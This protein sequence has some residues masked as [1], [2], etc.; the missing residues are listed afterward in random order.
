MKKNTL[1][2]ILALLFASVTSWAQEDVIEIGTVDELKAFR[3]AVNSGNQYTGKTVKL[4]SDLDLSSEA[5]W[6]PIGNLVAYPGQSFNGTFD[7]QDHTISNLTVVDNT[8]NYAVAGLFGSI[9]N[10]TIKNLTVSNVNIQ[11]THYAGGIV[12]Y[13]SNKPT[14]ENCHVKGGTISS[15]P[16][17]VGS[18]FDNGDK[19]GGIMGYATAY[20]TIIN[21]SVE[22]VTLTAYRDLGGVAGYSA[23]TVEDCQVKNVNLVQNLTNGY[24]TPTPTTIAEIVGRTETTTTLTDNTNTEV[25]KSTVTAVAKIGTVEYATLQAA[26]DA[27]TSG[28]TIDILKDFTL[29]T[30]TTDPS[31]KY[32]VNVNKSLTINGNNHTLT[33][34]TGKRALLLTGTDNTITLK[35]LT[36]KNNKADWTVGISNKLTANLDNVTLDGTGRKGGYNQVLT[37]TGDEDG[38]VVNITHG[39]V[40]K[41]NEAGKAHYAIIVW[42]KA[43]INVENSSLIGWANVYLKPAAAGSVVN[44]KN[45]NMTS[46]GLTGTSNNFAMI[47]SEGD[48]ND[49]T[50]EN[51]TIENHAQDGT[52]ESLLL[53]SGKNNTVKIIGGNYS[54]DNDTYGG[55]THNW[56][57]FTEEMGNGVYFDV[58]AK[59]K[60]SSYV[61]GTKG[62]TISD[63]TETVGGQQLYPLGYEPDVFYYWD[64]TSGQ[65]G[66]YCSLADP[67]TNGW[68][69]NKEYIKLKKDV[70]MTGDITITLTDGQSFSLLFDGHTLTAGDYSIKM[71]A[72][73]SIIT[74]KKVTDGL[75]TAADPSTY[76]IFETANTDGTYTYTAKEGIVKNVTQNIVYA[77]LQQAVNGVQTGETIQ[78]LDDI[79]QADHTTISKGG[80]TIDGQGKTLSCNYVDNDGIDPDNSVTDPETQYRNGEGALFFTGG[81]DEVT[82][83]GLSIKGFAYA[84]DVEGEGMTVTMNGG[85]TYGRAALN[86]HGNGNTFTFDGVTVNGL[87]KEEDSANEAFAA[88]VLD[89]DAN[90]NT[91]NITGCTVKT[92][93]DPDNGYNEEKFIELRGANNQVLIGGSTTYKCIPEDAGGFT[94]NFS[95]LANDKLFFDETAKATFAPMFDT[96]DLQISDIESADNEGFY[97]LTTTT[98]LVILD[99]LYRYP[100]FEKAYESEYFNADG[101][102]IK[103]LGPVTLAKDFTPA[104]ANGEMIVINLNGKTLK[105]G[106]YHINL[107]P[108]AIVEVIGGATDDTKNLFAATDPTTNIVATDAEDA[109]EI[110]GV[111]YTAANC[112]F[113]DVA[114]MFYESVVNE[115]DDPEDEDEEPDG[116]LVDGS[117][118]D[119]AADIA[120]TDN[121]DLSIF[122]KENESFTLNFGDYNF[123]GGKNMLLPNGAS[124]TTDKQTDL[125]KPATD[126]SYI[127]ETANANGTTYT[128]SVTAEEPTGSAVVK[129]ENKNVYYSTLQAATAAANE[130][131]VLIILQ[132]ITTNKQVDITKPLTI[133]SKEGSTYKVSS[134][135][136]PNEYINMLPLF[137]LTGIAEGSVVNIQDVNIDGFAY[138][139][140]VE[141]SVKGVTLNMT[142]TNG[143]RNITGRAAINNW[144]SDNTFNVDGYNVYAM[145]NQKK[146]TDPNTVVEQDLEWF[147]AFVDNKSM[148][149][150]EDED[151]DENQIEAKNNTYNISNVQVFATVAEGD[152]ISDAATSM[153][154]DLRGSGAKVIVENTEYHAQVDANR[155]GFTNLAYLANAVDNNK[156]WFDENSKTNFAP[157]F[158]GVVYGDDYNDVAIQETKDDTGKYPL[159]RTNG[160]VNLVI[161]VIDDDQNPND[162]TYY[163]PTLEEAINSPHFTEGD[164]F[165]EVLSDQTLTNDVTPNLSKNDHFRL[166]LNGHE[167]TAAD[168]KAIYL[169][170]AVNV[171]IKDDETG[172]LDGLFKPVDEENTTILSE[173]DGQGGMQYA[174]ANSM[175]ED[176]AFVLFEDLFTNNDDAEYKLSAEEKVDLKM[177]INLSQNLTCPSFGGDEAFINFGKYTI[178][179][180][181]IAIVKG[182]TITTDKQTTIFVPANDGCYVLE[183]DNGNT[184]SYTVTDN[185]NDAVARIDNRYFSTLQ[186][187]T[188]VA[189]DGETVVLLKDIET[190]QPVNITT[191][192]TLNGDGYEVTSNN[193]DPAFTVSGNGDVTIN[194]LKT[195]V[196]KGDAIEVKKGFSGK[197]TLNNDTIKASRRGIDVQNIAD[198]F[199]LTVNN[200]LIEAIFKGKDTNT[201]AETDEILNLD[202]K[203]NYVNMSPAIHFGNDAVSA[204]VNVNYSTLQGFAYGVNVADMSG[205]LEVNLSN[206]TFYGRAVVNNW[207]EGNTFNIDN[208]SVNGL[209]NEPKIID[210][211]T[212]EESD[213]QNE[214]FATIVDN[215][216]VNDGEANYNNY[217][218]NNTKFT[219]NA[220]GAAS[221]YASEKFIDLRGN[222]ARVK[223]TG[224]TTYEY[225]GTNEELGGFTNELF[226]KNLVDGNKV[227]FDETAKANFT[228][229]VDA[230]CSENYGY[231]GILDETDDTN[232]YPLDRKVVTVVLNIIDETTHDVVEQYFYDSLDKALESEKF[233]ENVQIQAMDDVTL[234]K[235]HTI[236]VPF[237]LNLNYSKPIKND[238]GEIIEHVDAI[239]TIRGN[240]KLL[241][242]P[243]VAVDVKGG[244]EATTDG[245]FGVA[246]GHDDDVKIL[247]S[248]IINDTQ[249][250]DGRRYT[251]GN[252][253]YGHIYDYTYF[254][255]L[256]ND[257]PDAE[258]ALWP[259]GYVRLE[260]PFALNK[261]LICPIEGDEAQPDSVYIDFN[262]KTLDPNGHAI[263]LKPGVNVF[264][265]SDD[266]SLEKLFNS[267]D[268]EY[269]VMYDI[270]NPKQEGPEGFENKEFDRKYYLM[271][272]GLAVVVAPATYCGEQ[273]KPSFIVKRKNTETLKWDTLEVNVD[274]TWRMVPVSEQNN[275]TDAKTYVSSII[276]E[277]ITF[278][279]VRRADFTINPRNITDCQV[280]GNSI[281]FSDLPAGGINAQQI[282]DRIAMTYECAVVEHHLTAT[283]KNVYTLK[284]KVD[285]KLADYMVEVDFTGL[286]TVTRDNVEYIYNI[287]I[288]EDIITLT[289]L[290]GADGTQNFVGT[291]KVDFNILPTGAIDIAECVVT[292]KAIYN[293]LTQKPSYDLLEVVYNNGGSKVVL[294]KDQYDIEVHGMETD[295]VN[296]KTYSNAITLKGTLTGTP[297]FYGTVNAD[298]VIAPRDLADTTFIAAINDTVKV[299]LKKNLDMTWTG[300]D[301]TNTI[302]IGNNDDD[303]I[304]LYMQVGKV[305]AEATNYTLVNAN[306]KYDY[307]YT[308]EPSPMKDP[309]EYKVI[310]TGRGNF[311]GMNEVKIAVLK[312]F[313]VTTDIALQVI[314]K[315]NEIREVYEAGPG[316]NPEKDLQGVVVKDNQNGAILIDGTHYTI[317]VKGQSETAYTA[318][319]PIRNQGVYIATITGKYPYYTPTAITKEFPAVFEYYTYAAGNVSGADD[320]DKFGIHVTSGIDRTATVGAKDGGVA[321]NDD[322]LTLTIDPK[323]KVKLGAN[324]PYTYVELTI[325]GIDD[326]AFNG[327]NNLHYV[328]ASKLDGYEPSS[329]SRNA[330]GPFNGISKQAIVYLDGDDVIGENY[331][332]ETSAGDFRCD[333]FKIYDDFDGNQKGFDGEG[334]GSHSWEIINIHEFT[335]KTL[336]NTRYFN[337][338]QHY[339]TLLPYDLP[340]PETLKAY[341][342]TAASDGIF[343]FREI[344]EDALTSF[345]PYVLIPS[346]AGNLLS[347]TDAV[348][349]VTATANRGFYPLRD[350]LH[351]QKGE[352]AKSGYVLYGS[353]IY[354]GHTSRNPVIEGTYIM[355]SG[356]QWKKIAPNSTYDGAC[357]LPMRAYI[358]KLNDGIEG[359][360]REFMSAKFIDGVK[361]MTNDM[362]GDDWSNAEVYDL[363]GRKVDTTQQMRKGVYIVNGQKRIRK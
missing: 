253:Y 319:N 236:D 227:W 322:M 278:Q 62:Q 23:G 65:E 301:L 140:N 12:A 201:G 291:R 39:S 314:P 304:L 142:S 275:Y 343:G 50:L 251:A 158:D 362:V 222:S 105:G 331:V 1:Y 335:A 276:I 47:V 119:L 327:T 245:V 27:A 88:F 295:Y 305:E 277:G 109:G 202:P 8:P 99:D 208:M 329:L 187:A 128:Y 162:Y 70:T 82:I 18:G 354:M 61:D 153:F 250:I 160:G 220:D 320:A 285:D 225:V 215:N 332:Y 115:N 219:A 183:I 282:A 127:L 196:T 126:G 129:N 87:N 211:D 358:L 146:P 79:A 46:T 166:Q 357:I 168:G 239:A 97:P 68:L 303:N 135:A 78:I 286:E 6:K 233:G 361:E 207:G 257:D 155:Y 238:Q 203:E 279:G 54:T 173:T 317:T 325:N 265:N 152:D 91:L 40:I 288:Y 260:M 177:N 32:N 94:N 172:K 330:D 312:E 83:Q 138:A 24:K 298:Y 326:N 93:V 323:K 124:V 186:G 193:V 57:S 117:T 43:T 337:A 328:D 242:N 232:L 81:T 351:R 37:I 311:T 75:F 96:V 130:G 176:A 300:Q 352:I 254:N 14:I 89:D 63:A 171:D 197:L 204:K 213:S 147:A 111:D 58:A 342:L 66:T 256:F 191:A 113:D 230:F 134:G 237:E 315:V 116:W 110:V 244:S 150:D 184:F 324:P 10:G 53:L 229:L 22:N 143:S 192:I 310:F 180:G 67:F 107:A 243:G 212:H 16:E 2:I 248:D 217:N 95:D 302:K 360:S 209:N 269:T 281:K 316:L 157:L 283:G 136:N 308:I 266:A 170:P 321:V 224:N 161:T 241:L 340:L 71:P 353:M 221:S 188:N 205:K 348:V 44:I 297:K 249:T 280:T 214:F 165:I 338:G 264:T 175:Y 38:A 133:K 35:N 290:E 60:F 59:N 74:D 296:A 356:N 100:S 306:N 363:Q 346:A 122:I 345:M 218:I 42:K 48:G 148:P 206:G 36:V 139:V 149:E 349:K 287:G 9:V 289:A 5:N 151:E 292:S 92:T 293:S 199:E 102:T 11:S 73:V 178:E 336:T 313:N 195:Y 273:Q 339:T 294:T 341:N 200:S 25:T 137:N 259:D 72:G 26:V 141:N 118:I 52:Y 347:T 85:K 174:A 163:Y 4:T 263:L 112:I 194:K 108:G 333:E 255:D 274:Y 167:I 98:A 231:I 33:S 144:G 132:D 121:L 216:T 189:K 30:V 272:D 103:L 31:D 309:G 258:L 271:K 51:N 104:T 268:P 198:G 15:T 120:M 210:S 13:T 185:V 77:T 159:I 154:I 262:G 235:N 20:S 90:N 45:S 284:K 350:N 334:Q 69:A 307:S 261:D 179:G 80:F 246:A 145:N 270:L 86:V 34:A 318:T 267:A 7:G 240:G 359:H 41:T 226:V 19:V 190:N 28:S 223:I 64:T 84:I 106:G 164:A 234:D 125:F 131:D 49:I 355:Q 344:E 114:T 156:V 169:K 252:V 29:T 123:T 56:D 181:T 247:T 101:S 182:D 76:A 55:L 21:C 3:D 228:L 299:V 17:V